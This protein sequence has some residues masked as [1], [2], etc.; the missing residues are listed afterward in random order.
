M[1][2]LFENISRNWNI[3][4]V[5]W[6]SQLRGLDQTPWRSLTC[7]N[8]QS[9]DVQNRIAAGYKPTDMCGFHTS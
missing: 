6:Y 2:A 5:I 3:H 1:F 8:V 4:P 9:R 7:N